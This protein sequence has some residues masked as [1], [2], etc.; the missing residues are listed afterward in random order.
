[1]DT[2]V[3]VKQPFSNEIFLDN[4]SFWGF[5]EKIILVTS[6]I[7]TKKEIKLIKRFFRFI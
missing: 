7:G 6:T 1:M 2:D 3:E 5:E 4:D